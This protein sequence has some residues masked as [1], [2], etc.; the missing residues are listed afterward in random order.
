[1]LDG[2]VVDAGVGVV[3][4]Y[5][6]VIAYACAARILHG[7]VLHDRPAEVV[8]ADVIRG[9]YAGVRKEDIRPR[10]AGEG[11]LARRSYPLR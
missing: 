10:A 7:A 9:V 6:P 4:P 11:D 1:M 5:R 2:T 8:P 3:Q